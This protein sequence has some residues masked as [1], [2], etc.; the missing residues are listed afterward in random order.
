MF[1]GGVCIVSGSRGWVC[2]GVH[3]CIWVNRFKKHKKQTRKDTHGPIVHDFPATMAGNFPKI[4]AWVMGGTDR[5]RASQRWSQMVAND[6]Y[7]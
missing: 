4:H 6:D 1:G 2:M 5:T 7:S 3:G